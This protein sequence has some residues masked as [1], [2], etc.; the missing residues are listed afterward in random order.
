VCE[1]HGSIHHLQCVGPCRDDIW[2]N[3]EEVPVD[4]A[5]MRVRAVPRCPRCGGVARPNILMFDDRT[6]VPDR[7]QAQGARL[8]AFLAAHETDPL[9]VIEMGA[10]TAIPSIRATSERTGRRPGCLVVRINPREPEIGAPHLPLAAGA[11]AGL[12]AI[13]AALGE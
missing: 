13:D 9:V 11:L 5:T 1:I 2:D 8:H 12:Q 3:R 6:W 10:G 7:S 4:L